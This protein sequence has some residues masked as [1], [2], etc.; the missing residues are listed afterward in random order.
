[1]ILRINMFKITLKFLMIYCEKLKMQ[2]I[3]FKNKN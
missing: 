2:N 3:K 1:M